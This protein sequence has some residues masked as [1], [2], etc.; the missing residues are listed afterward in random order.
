MIPE[1]PVTLA[2]GDGVSLEARLA[3]PVAPT[4]GVVI[5]H[6][7]P[8]YGGDMDNPVVVR[9]QEV[10]GGLDLATLR[11]NFRGVGGSTGVHGE[12]VAEQ[13]DARA[14][15][16]VLEK[17]IGAGPLAIVGYSFGA[18]IAATIAQRD[19][20][21]AA[22]GLIAPPLTMYDFA[23]AV[24]S[25]VPTLVVA[26]TAD[27]YCPPDSLARLTAKVPALNAVAIDGADHFFFGKLFPLGQAIDAWARQLLR[28]RA[29]S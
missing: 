8:F 26:G 6:P 22:V 12:G 1:R 7:H 14:A 3:T 19:M 16:D 21:L 10:C 25:R 29:G 17:A 2:V 4:G 11:F 15:L 28:P 13:D 9:V 23:S 5:C 20:R 18:R 24:D 27:P